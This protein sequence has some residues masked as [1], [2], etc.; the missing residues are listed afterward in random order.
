MS[1]EL[2]FRIHNNHLEAEFTGTR[3][4]D[5]ELGKVLDYGLKYPFNEKNIT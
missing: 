5:D 3:D 1:I 2:K 4:T